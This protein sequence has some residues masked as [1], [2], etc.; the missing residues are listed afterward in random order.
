MS[1]D[2]SSNGAQ[3]VLD[4]GRV[5]RRAVRRYA[6]AVRESATDVR[7]GW[8]RRASTT[9]GRHGKL[10]PKAIKADTSVLNALIF[11]DPGM[12]QGDMSFEFGS[13]NQPEHL[14]GQLTLDEW[15]PRIVR[16]FDA[17]AVFD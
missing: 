12:K 1:F 8:R 16:R 2:M 4:L 11:P 9:A 14:D 15:E 3:I 5:E 17:V 13:E 10:Y 6:D 7:D